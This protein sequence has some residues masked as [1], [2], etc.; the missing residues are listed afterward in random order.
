[1][2]QEPL[3]CCLKSE[4]PCGWGIKCVGIG[5]WAELEAGGCAS[6]FFFFFDRGLTDRQPGRA[7]GGTDG[8]SGGGGM[9]PGGGP[10]G[11]G[12]LLKKDSQLGSQRR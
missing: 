5:G 12:G 11:G 3:N 8:I 7:G 2:S 10:G 9:S 4:W 1:M 6:D